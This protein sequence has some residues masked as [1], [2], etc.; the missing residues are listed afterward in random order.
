MA[1]VDPNATSLVW[2]CQAAGTEQP[3]TVGQEFSL[4]CSGESV[5]WITDPKLGELKLDPPK[6][7]PY[8]LHLLKVN[9]LSEHDGQFTV[10]TYMTAEKGTVVAKGFV[11]TDGQHR[12]TLSPLELQVKSVITPEKN[13]ERKPYGG[14]EPMKMVYPLWLWLAFAFLFVGLLSLF[15]QFFMKRRSHKQF[16]EELKK[17][18]TALTPYNQ[19]NKELRQLSRQLLSTSDSPWLATLRESFFMYLSREYRIPVLKWSERDVIASI[20]KTSVAEFQHF[21]KELRL[22]FR[23]LEKA[24]RSVNK[25][26][27]QDAFQLMELCREGVEKIN[28]ERS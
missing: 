3:L 18:S 16:L 7:N 14:I 8:A 20:E 1:G 17:K 4:S 13:P 15:I 9:Q 6:D 10:T 24:S 25:L 27:L 23:E 21:E 28:K 19:F 12:V 26:T 22:A 11:L 2:S 5:P